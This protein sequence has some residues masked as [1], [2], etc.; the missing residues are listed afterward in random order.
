MMRAVKSAVWLAAAILVAGTAAA[1]TADELIEKHLAAMGG[2]AALG[3]L[4][5]QTASG[6]ITV[7]VQGNDL[8]GSIDVFHK[9]PNKSRTFFK[10]DLSAFGMG[11]MVVD[12][13]CDGTTAFESN[14][15]QGDREVTGS[16]LQA[17]LNETFPTPFL[18]YKEAGTKVEVVGKEKLEGRDVTVLVV[19]PKTGPASRQYLDENYLMVRSVSKMDVP[20]LGG[21]VEQTTDVSDY[22][23]IEGI[24]VPF[25]IRVATPVSGVGITLTRVEFNKPIEDA[26][27][28]RTGK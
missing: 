17:M 3:K 23:E 19:T 5:T 20:E 11:E 24:K 16:Q 15:M 13:R 6:T 12:R 27:F 25:V 2:R 21:E 26:M 28:S 14:S 9:A 7:S 10:M 8:T 1:Q 22:R 18:T 4:T